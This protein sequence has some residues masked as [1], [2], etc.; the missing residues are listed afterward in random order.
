MRRDHC[1]DVQTGQS[2]T[3]EVQPRTLESRV[4]DPPVV[5]GFLGVGTAF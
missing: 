4:Q 5:V 2:V 1:T 3:A